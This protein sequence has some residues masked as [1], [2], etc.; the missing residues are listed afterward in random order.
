MGVN[1]SSKYV[2]EIRK[3]FEEKHLATYGFVMNDREIEI[4]T[5]RVFAIKK[6]PLPKIKVTFGNCDK[7]RE[8]RKVIINDDWVNVDVYVR[9]K[10]SKGFRIRGPA[11]IEEYSSTTVIK[12][13]WNAIIDDS[14]IL[15]RE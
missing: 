13:G 6:R 2:H 15:V 10:L 4:V 12:D 5:I 7:P 1:N 8:V 9:E 14:I 11:I 3:V